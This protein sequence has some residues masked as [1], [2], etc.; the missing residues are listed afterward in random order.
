[1]GSLKYTRELNVQF[2]SLGSQMKSTQ[3]FKRRLICLGAG[4][5]SG[6]G[7]M[8]S[9]RTSGDLAW[10]SGCSQH[11]RAAEGGALLD[12]EAGTVSISLSVSRSVWEARKGHNTTHAARST[13]FHRTA[14]TRESTEPLALVMEER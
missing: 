5:W 12:L 13:L 8:C 10:T 3:Y 11:T 7:S 14:G 9:A 1:M 6:L 4:T 2:D